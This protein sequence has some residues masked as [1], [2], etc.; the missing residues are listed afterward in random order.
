MV[1]ILDEQAEQLNKQIEADCPAV[2]E[3]LSAKGKAIYFPKMGI[4]SQS[5]EAAGKEINATIGIA[6]EEDGTPMILPGIARNCS[7]KPG[8]MV[9]YAPSPGKPEIRKLWKETLAA[10]NP[11]VAGRQFSLPVV[12]CALT[13]GLS[14]CAYLFCDE[15][16]PLVVPDLYWENYDLIFA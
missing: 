16:D 14:M 11:S 13:H 2:L 8:E 12:T 9:S 7:L 10:K 5:A 1:N 3:M 4:L 15:D 6:L